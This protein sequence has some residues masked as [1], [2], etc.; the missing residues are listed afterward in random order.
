MWLILAGRGWGKTRTGAQD[1]AGYAMANPESRC[2]VVAPTQGDLRRVCF[3]GSSG[4]LSCIPKE[5][6]WTG[7]GSAYNRTAMEIKLWNGSII[8]GYAAIEPDSCVVRSFIG[9][10]QMNWR[11]GDIQMLMT[12]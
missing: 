7:D 12:R 8:Q 10:G 3:E 2:G 11:L 9:C 4:L 5:C 6:L 1:I